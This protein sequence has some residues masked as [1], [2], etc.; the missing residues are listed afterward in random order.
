MTVNPDGKKDEMGKSSYKSSDGSLDIV[1]EI[2]G[3]ENPQNTSNVISKAGL[4]GD[5]MKRS[6][7]V[8]TREWG[9][10]EAYEQERGK[11]REDHLGSREPRT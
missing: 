8:V 4:N 2:V 5:S 11:Q 10:T 9:V 1:R 3:L 7:I 6:D